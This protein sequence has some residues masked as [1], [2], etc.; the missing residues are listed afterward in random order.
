MKRHGLI[1][2]ALQ[3]S[4]SVHYLPMKLQIFFHAPFRAVTRQRTKLTL[5]ADANDARGGRDGN[6]EQWPCEFEKLP[7]LIFVWLRF[8]RAQKGALTSIRRYW[9]GWPIRQTWHWPRSPYLNIEPVV[10]LRRQGQQ[11]FSKRALYCT[12]QLTAGLFFFSAALL[13][14]NF[15][16]FPFQVQ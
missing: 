12:Q 15:A 1:V 8:S 11:G 7:L 14:D 3:R 13:F 2:S 10:F 16:E 6:A 5:C 4:G 9:N